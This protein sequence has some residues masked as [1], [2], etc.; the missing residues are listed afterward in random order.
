[1]RLEEILK[2]MNEENV[3]L[4]NSLK[5]FEEANRLILFCNKQLNST[6]KKMEELIKNRDNELQLDENGKPLTKEFS[7]RSEEESSPF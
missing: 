2:E 1:M 7:L 3:H 4:E 6:Q 5:L